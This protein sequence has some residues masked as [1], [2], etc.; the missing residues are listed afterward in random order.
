MAQFRSFFQ[1]F[2]THGVCVLPAEVLSNDLLRVDPE[3]RMMPPSLRKEASVL[4]LCYARVLHCFADGLYWALVAATPDLIGAQHVLLTE[5]QLHHALPWDVRLVDREPDA[6]RHLMFAHAQD[7]K[8]VQRSEPSEQTVT[9]PR[10]TA[11]LT[12]APVLPL[13]PVADSVV[14]VSLSQL[15]EALDPHP[16]HKTDERLPRNKKRSPFRR[17]I[18]SFPMQEALLRVMIDALMT[19][20]YQAHDHLTALILKARCT[21]LAQI[22]RW[23][24]ASRQRVVNAVPVWNGEQQQVAWQLTVG[25]PLA[26]YAAA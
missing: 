24:R 8:P 15:Q 23:H 20:L 11:T 25:V 19:Q 22:E 3:T 7:V 4:G 18:G 1:R 2:G 6:I 13:E 14:E 17:P 5:E 10:A 12:P 26:A 21:L 16:P 9:I